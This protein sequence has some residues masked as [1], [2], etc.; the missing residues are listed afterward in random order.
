MQAPHPAMAEPGRRDRW[1]ASFHGGHSA[2]YCDHAR[3]PLRAVLDAAIARGLWAFGVTEHAPRVEPHRLYD[4]ERAMG[5]T[6]ETL[7]EKFAA[8]AR[9][10]DAL[11]AEYA[12]RLEVLK[13]FEAEVVPE[14]GWLELTRQWRE[15]YGFDYVVG[16]I[17]YVAGHIIDYRRE[18]YLRAPWA[19][20]RNASSPRCWGIST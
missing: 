8:Y 9:E 16:S 6:V 12:G 20:W 10:L 17:H 11:A 1:R 7:A 3:S 2:A 4:E 5:W 19:T 15:R 13:G 18:H 14:G